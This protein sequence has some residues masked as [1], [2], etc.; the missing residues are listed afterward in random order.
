MGGLDILECGSRE[1]PCS[2]LNQALTRLTAERDTMLIARGTYAESVVIAN[3]TVRLIGEGIL[4]LPPMTE[5]PAL[6]VTQEGTLIV[7]GL[8]I[9]A[10]TGIKCEDFSKLTVRNALL[11]EGEG[12]TLKAVSCD[13]LVEKSQFG[14]HKTAISAEN[15]SLQIKGTKF[16]GNGGDGS[17][18][19]FRGGSLLIENCELLGRD[20]F[21]V[22]TDNTDVRIERTTIDDKIVAVDVADGSLKM[23]RSVLSNSLLQALVITNSAFTVENNFIVKTGTGEYHAQPVWIRAS[24][25]VNPHVFAFNTIADNSL[26]PQATTSGLD[27]SVP[28]PIELSNN[29]IYH[30]TPSRLPPTLGTCKHRYSNIQSFDNGNGNISVDPEFVDRNG[31]DYHLS[32]TSPLIDAGDP[33]ILDGVDIDGE[34]RPAGRAPDI[35]ADEVLP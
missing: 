34:A 22:T 2:S 25:P 20:V 15:S 19:G 28:G 7:D 35:G 27:C 12:G 1:T 23:E 11:K 24:Q 33:T 26:G 6:L 3:R 9:L 16:M 14:N 5:Q 17:Q 32:P 30:L 29:I 18:M 31:G 4:A 10:P 13:M 21:G 8:T